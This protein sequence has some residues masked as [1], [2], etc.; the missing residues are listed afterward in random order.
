MDS[1]DECLKSVDVGVQ[2][3]DFGMQWFQSLK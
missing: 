2:I 1:F 3:Q